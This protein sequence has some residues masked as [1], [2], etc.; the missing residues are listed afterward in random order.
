MSE[1][2]F[3]KKV[4]ARYDGGPMFFPDVLGPTV[5]L[6]AELTGDGQALEFGV[7]TGHAVFRHGPGYVGYDRYTDLI[8][9]QAGGRWSGVGRSSRARPG[10]AH[11]PELL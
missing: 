1:N 4:A 8:A 11:L 6:L 3:G 7:G 2:Y 10:M 9:Q 5:D